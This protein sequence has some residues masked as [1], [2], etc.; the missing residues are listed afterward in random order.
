MSYAAGPI[1]M[2]SLPDLNVK[3]STTVTGHSLY[4]GF[5]PKLNKVLAVRWEYEQGGPLYLCYLSYETGALEKEVTIGDT[6]TVRFL[7]NG[8]YLLTSAGDLLST[9]S[10]EIMRHFDF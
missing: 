7:Q 4:V 1:E 5:Q 10:G 6:S 8:Q 9:E 3:W 2:L